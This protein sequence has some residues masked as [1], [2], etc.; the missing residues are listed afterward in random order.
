MALNQLEKTMESSHDSN[1]KKLYVEWSHNSTKKIA[2]RNLPHNSADK[3]IYP[4]YTQRIPMPK[5]QKQ[6]PTLATSKRMQNKTNYSLRSKHNHTENQERINNNHVIKH[7]PETEHVLSKAHLPF[8]LQRL[9]HHLRYK[10]HLPTV[11][12]P[13]LFSNST[14]LNNMDNSNETPHTKSPSKS[15]F[16]M[17]YFLSPSKTPIQHSQTS[18]STDTED[19]EL[20][21]AILGIFNTQLIA[22]MISRDSVVREVRDCILIID[23]VR[24]EKL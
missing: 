24:C 4:N 16:S 2:V 11:Q 19:R 9:L 8:S 15:N 13:T 20:S 3:Q 17:S 7:K 5:N 6:K 12:Q 18:P 21:Q 14:N 23:E 10:A 1:T 22:A